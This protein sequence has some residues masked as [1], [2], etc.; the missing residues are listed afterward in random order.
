MKKTTLVKTVLIAASLPLLAGCVERQVVYRDQPVYVQPPPAAPP[1]APP[2]EVVVADPAPPPPQVEVIPVQP[3][4]SFIW[5]GGSWEWRGRWCWTGGHW[6]P[7]PHPGAVWVHG[8]WAHRGHGR[9]WVGA[10]WR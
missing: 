1:F 3:D 6:V 10:H 4:P 5:V 2:A 7:R 9:V 8:G